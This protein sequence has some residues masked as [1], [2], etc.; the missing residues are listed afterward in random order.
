MVGTYCS[1]T[2]G[3][4]TGTASV[5]SHSREGGFMSGLFVLQYRLQKYEFRGVCEDVQYKM[6]GERCVL[7]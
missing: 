3:W 7:P 1:R 5:V 6:F 4:L 2:A